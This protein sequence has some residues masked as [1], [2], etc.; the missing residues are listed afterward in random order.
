MKKVIG[1]D[2]KEAIVSEETTVRTRNGVHYLLTPE[3]NE[4]LLAKESAWEAS[5]PKRLAMRADKTL[6]GS[7]LRAWPVEK[8]LEAMQDKLNGDGTKFNQM[9]EELSAIKNTFKGA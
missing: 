9:N 8:Q 5:E 2:G 4:V 3:D 7:Y 1:L 6:S